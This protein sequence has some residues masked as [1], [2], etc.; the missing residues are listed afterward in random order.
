M[1]SNNRKWARNG[2]GDAGVRL[3]ER[4]RNALTGADAGNVWDAAIAEVPG[5]GCV[6]TGCGDADSGSGRGRVVKQRFG[7]WSEI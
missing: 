3:L 4:M 2:A 1:W 6:T 5:F 7:Y